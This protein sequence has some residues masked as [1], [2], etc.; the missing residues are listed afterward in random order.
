MR[1]PGSPTD[2]VDFHSEIAQKFDASYRFDANRLERVRVWNDL[3]DRY[4][5]TAR[6]AYD[7]GCGPG[8]LTREVACRGIETIAID[9][10]AGMLAIAK[11]AAV[12]RGLSNIEFRQYRLPIADITGFRAADIVL[13]F[14]VIEYLESVSRALIFL[15]G[16]SIKGGTIIFSVSNKH[17]LSRKLVRFVHRLTGRPRYFGLVRHFM[18]IDEIKLKLHDEGLDYIEHCYIGRADR[19]NRVLGTLLPARFASNMIVVVARRKL[20]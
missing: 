17:S 15:R 5:G 4:A 20:E 6:L 13:S 7:I 16:L 19:L 10:A 11:Q 3:L 2:A 9:G 18:D 12:E 1:N 8:V 14:S